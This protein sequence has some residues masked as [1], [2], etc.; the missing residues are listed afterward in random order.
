[1]FYSKTFRFKDF[2]TNQGLWMVMWS[3]TIV[4]FMEL[5]L[6]LRYSGETNFMG[7]GSESRLPKDGWDTFMKMK[8]KGENQNGWSF[9]GNP[10]NDVEHA[11]MVYVLNTIVGSCCDK[12]AAIEF[13]TE[14]ELS[15]M[16]TTTELTYL[17]KMVHH[18]LES[19]HWHGN[20][21]TLKFENEYERALVIAEGM[22]KVSNY[23]VLLND[24]QHDI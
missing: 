20:K 7:K 12:V 4:K 3:F 16:L 13:N 8:F 6:Q 21:E 18:P 14:F 23:T 19:Y 17:S 2:P 11:L 10:E 15:P 22:Q 24:S 9:P 5:L 1:M